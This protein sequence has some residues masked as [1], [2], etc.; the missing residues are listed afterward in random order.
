MKFDSDA[1]SLSPED[2]AFLLQDT[3]A[4]FPLLSAALSMSTST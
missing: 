1:V 3:P 4:Y 2:A